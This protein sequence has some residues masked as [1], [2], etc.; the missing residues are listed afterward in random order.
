LASLHAVAGFPIFASVPA[1]AGVLANG[2]ILVVAI[3]AV[4][5][6]PVAGL[7]A[8]VGFLLLLAIC[9][10]AGV[11]V[12]AVV[13]AFTTEIFICTCVFKHTQL[14]TLCTMY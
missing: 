9:A 5:V 1:L 11:P 8:F 4:A 13:P 3:P 7:P 6:L 2:S 10:V 14:Q 12:V